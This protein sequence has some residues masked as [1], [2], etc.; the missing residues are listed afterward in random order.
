M[1]DVK[2]EFARHLAGIGCEFGTPRAHV[3]EKLRLRMG[4][5]RYAHFDAV[6]RAVRSPAQQQELYTLFEDLVEG[7][8]LR[9]LDPDATFDAS[10]HLYRRS[11]PLLTP[12]VRVVELG[13]WTGGLASFIAARH[14]QCEVIGV[15]AARKV[16]SACNAFYRLPNLRFQPW[17]YRRPKPEDLEPADVLLCSLGVTHEVSDTDELPDPAEVRRSRPYQAERDHAAVFFSTWRRASKDGGVLLTALRLQLFIRFL[18]WVDAAGG[19]GWAPRLDRLWHVGPPGG[20]GTLTGMVF[21][22]RDSE[23]LAEDWIVDRWAWFNRGGHLH[24]CL[25]G[26]AALAAYRALG[27]RETLAARQYLFERRLTGDEVGLAGSTGYVFTQDAVSDYRLLLVTQSR[28]REL[29]TGVS[30]RGSST[31]ITDDGVFAGGA[32]AA[33]RPGGAEMRPAAAPAS[34]CPFFSGPTPLTAPGDA[35]DL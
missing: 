4:E 28:A 3:R 9:S 12:G 24:A 23:P 14:P 8:L 16:I 7:N 15:D 11:V 13:C 30:V 35:E 10:F 32:L 18:A 19:A 34:A 22:A 21:E 26:G 25:K 29:A 6:A 2:N 20:G 33:T 1:S 31:P 27:G 17:N 5:E